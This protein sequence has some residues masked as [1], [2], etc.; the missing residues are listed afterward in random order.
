MVKGE[1]RK[2]GRWK[3]KCQRWRY[4]CLLQAR[5]SYPMHLSL[6]AQRTTL[7]QICSQW[8]HRETNILGEIWTKR[9][10][11]DFHSVCVYPLN[12]SGPPIKNANARR[13]AAICSLHTSYDVVWGREPW[14]LEHRKCGKKPDRYLNVRPFFVCCAVL[15]RYR[16]CYNPSPVKAVLQPFIKCK[17]L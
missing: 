17:I 9:A 16:T 10:L 6:P 1:N 7:G 8:K 15:S 14:C 4:S 3:G 12:M 13:G 2:R 11:W 5:Y